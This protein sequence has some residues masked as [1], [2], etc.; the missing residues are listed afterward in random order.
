MGGRTIHFLSGLPRTGSTLLGA[1]LAQNPAIHVTPTSPLADLLVSTALAVTNTLHYNYDHHDTYEQIFGA[2]TDIVYR[3]IER[4]IIFDKNRY[5]PGSVED[6]RRLSPEP[7]IICTVRPIAEIV[8]SYVV[9]A[10]RSRGKNFLDEHIL[11]DGQPIN[12]DNRAALICRCYLQDHLRVLNNGLT[13][14]PDNILLVEY[15]DLI[16]TPHQVLNRIYAFCEIEHFRHDITS[17]DDSAVE[18]D[19][20]QNMPGLHAIRRSL[21]KISTPPDDIL[22][23]LAMQFVS[24]FTYGAEQTCHGNS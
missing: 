9:L 4:P 13:S 12:N 23:P 1:I 5:W 20:V 8:A 14:H 6:I 10:E 16:N 7:K 21:T 3:D 24:Q 2:I 17:I 11:R 15:D 22:S 18:N 19:D